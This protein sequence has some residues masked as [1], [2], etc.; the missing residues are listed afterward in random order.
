MEVGGYWWV[1]VSLVLTTAAAGAVG[2][3][4]RPRLEGVGRVARV[5]GDV[6]VLDRQIVVAASIAL[7]VLC[8]V[9]W[10]NVAKPWG[11]GPGGR[12]RR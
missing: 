11:R 6:G 3:A 8:A 9:T 7:V 1:L 4:L 5:G 2:F 10:I 12:G